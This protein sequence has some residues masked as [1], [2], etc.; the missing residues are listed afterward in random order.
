[1]LIDA[2][3]GD[4]GTYGHGTIH[5]SRPFNPQ[6]GATPVTNPALALVQ[7]FYYLINNAAFPGGVQAALHM[8]DQYGDVRVISNPHLS[9]LDNQKGLAGLKNNRTEPVIFITPGVV[10]NESDV[11]R[12]FDELRRRME[13]RDGVFPPRTWPRPCLRCRREQ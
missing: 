1:M 5:R 2:V 12:V 4:S 7:G 9:P 10:E 8:L 11:R 13:T 6:S 3:A